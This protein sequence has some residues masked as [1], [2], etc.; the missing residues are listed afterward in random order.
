MA[1]FNVSYCLS[2]CHQ[3]WIRLLI[4]TNVPLGWLFSLNFPTFDVGIS[5]NT[6]H[7]G[8]LICLDSSINSPP[9]CKHKFK[10][11][12]KCGPIGNYV[13]NVL[14]NE[15]SEGIWVGVATSGDV[16]LYHQLTITTWLIHV[17]GKTLSKGENVIKVCIIHSYVSQ[18]VCIFFSVRDKEDNSEG[19]DR[20][21]SL[22]QDLEL[23]KGNRLSAP[24][25]CLII[26][27]C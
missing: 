19:Q 14:I 2:D 13:K 26:S 24:G 9:A 10:Q 6:K 4:V 12:L 27:V 17:L 15:G 22:H 8:V 21:S 20:A 5:P 7:S 1:K 11:L 3:G 18:H 16:T 25:H 23:D